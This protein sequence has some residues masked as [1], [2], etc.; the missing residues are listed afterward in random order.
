[1]KENVNRAGGTWP[2]PGELFFSG[3]MGSNRNEG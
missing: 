3:D 1:M 2:G